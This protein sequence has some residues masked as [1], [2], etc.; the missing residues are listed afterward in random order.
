[1]SGASD[2]E[3]NHISRGRLKVGRNRVREV[4]DKATE[5]GYLDGNNPVPPY[6]EALFPD[7]VDGRSERGSSAWNELEPHLAWIK[8]RLTT[9]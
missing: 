2:I 1:M 4:R 7:P 5:A 6:P 9:G 3:K 8:E